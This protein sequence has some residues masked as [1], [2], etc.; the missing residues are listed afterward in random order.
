MPQVTVGVPVYN[1]AS[2]LEESLTCLRGQSFRDFEV[3]IFDNCSDDATAEIAQRFCAA[4]PRFRYFRHPENKGAVP[5]FLSV[6]EAAQSPFFLWR[7]ADDT[8]DAGYIETLLALLLAHPERD[9]AVARIVSA[10]PDGRVM[11][12]HLVSPLIEKGGVSGR[13]AQLFCS[14]HASWIYGLFRREAMIPIL[15]EVLAS[16]PYVW[17]WDNVTMFALE[18]DRKVIGTNSTTFYQYLREPRPRGGRALRAVRDDAKVEAGRSFMAFAHRHVD[19]VIPNPAGRWF[20]HLAVAYF[21][22]KR[23]CSWS[24]RLRRRLA[25]RF[26]SVHGAT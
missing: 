16:Y 10:L 18:F 6:L 1:G 19:R 13:L 11:H 2:F 14:H 24:K 23:A 4:D 26:G 7:A 17:G 8:S 21:G 15:R 9:I 25:R 3:L 12:E 20:Y 5:N 22:H